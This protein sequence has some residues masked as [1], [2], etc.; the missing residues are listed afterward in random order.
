M[1]PIWNSARLVCILIRSHPDRTT[2]EITDAEQEL[3]SDDEETGKMF[4]D[5]IAGEIRGVKR[6]GYIALVFLA[7]LLALD[8]API[9]NT[10]SLDAVQ[11]F[12]RQLVDSA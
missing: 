11:Q 2:E 5:E 6:L 3:K 1:K 7:G 12:V 10:D 9:L 4:G 8:F